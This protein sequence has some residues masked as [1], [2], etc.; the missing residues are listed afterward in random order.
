MVSSN[1]SVKLDLKNSDTTLGDLRIALR[2][3]EQWAEDDGRVKVVSNPNFVA[4][5]VNVEVV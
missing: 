1:F 4:F 3:L 5:S 2:Q